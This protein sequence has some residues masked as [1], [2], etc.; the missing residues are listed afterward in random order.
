MVD[1]GKKIVYLLVGA[2]GSGKT[3]IGT[4]LERTLN[5]HFLKVEQRLIEHIGFIDSNGE[6][7][8][9]DGYDLEETWIDE[10][11]QSNNEVI[12][13]ATGSSK[14]LSRFLHQLGA[15]Y[16]L[17]LIRI[18]CPLD[19]CFERIKE[20]SAMNQFNV[21]VEKIKSINIASHNV[22][23]DW[24]LEIDNAGPAPESEILAMFRNLRMKSHVEHKV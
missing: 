10:I 6:D 9:N 11:L 20:R 24:S 1:P 8:V 17:K 21:P 13:E 19:T 18:S 15:K 4:L 23:L 14:Y 22:Q 7:L 12:S 2:K 5:I 16:I 3:H